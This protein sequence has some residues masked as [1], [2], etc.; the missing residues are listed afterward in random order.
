M[1]SEQLR[2]SL[3]LKWLHYYR[4]NREWID[5]LGIW[6]TCEGQR[7]PS[8][9]F[10]LGVLSLLEPNLTQLLP[11][12]VELNSNSDRIIKALGLNISPDRELSRLEE[13]QRMLPGSQSSEVSATAVTPASEAAIPAPARH[14]DEDCRGTHP[15][16]DDRTWGR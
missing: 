1:N 11:L 9:G 13:S 5:H 4:D 3:K 7:R 8:S 10:I 12:V 6:I 16:T 14:L 2:Q 15:Q